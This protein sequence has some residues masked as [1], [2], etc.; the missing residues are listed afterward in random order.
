MYKR[1]NNM[2]DLY[3][4]LGVEYVKYIKCEYGIDEEEVDLNDKDEF[5]E[6]VYFCYCDRLVEIVNDEQILQHIVDYIGG[7]IVGNK[8]VYE[9]RDCDYHFT[10]AKGLKLM[11]AKR[12]YSIKSVCGEES[13]T[14][15]K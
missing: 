13:I 15:T 4:D 1:I 10:P 12:K 3:N 7:E 8:V 2:K 11:N 5:E 6:F 9:F 14:I